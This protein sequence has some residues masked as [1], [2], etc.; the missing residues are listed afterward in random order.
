MAALT[1]I[2]YPNRVEKIVLANAAGLKPNEIDFNLVYSL[3]FSTR[4]EIR[5]LVKLV[6]YNQAI[7]G[8]ELFVDQSISLRVAANDGYTIDSLI[9]SAKRSEDFLD[10]QLANIKKPT[11][12]IW[13]KQDGLLPLA[14]AQKFKDGIADSQLVI[15]D[16]CGHVPQ[17]EK[18][19]DFNAAVLS[20][21]LRP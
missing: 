2:K 19:A 20:F 10:S 15:F 1:A 8:S 17:V 11:L 6:F 7:F 5:K 3:N 13:G 14:D 18:A 4:D 12:I 9:E 16:Q 21:V